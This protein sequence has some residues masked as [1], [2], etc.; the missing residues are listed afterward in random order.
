MLAGLAC[1]FFAKERPLLNKINI[2]IDGPAG[3]GKST[4]ARQVA[5]A[6]G[7]IYVD[8]GAMYRAVTWKALRAGIDLAD[9]S[10]L[11]RMAKELDIQLLPGEVSQK[12][13]LNGEDITDLIRTNEV[14]TTVSLVAQLAEIRELLVEKQQEMARSKGVVMDGRDIGTHVLPD[15]EVKVFLTASARRRAERRYLE[16]RERQEE[17]SLDRLEQEITARDKLDSER[18]TSPL[19]QAKDATLIDSTD[20][21]IE[22]VVERILALSRVRISEV[23]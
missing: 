2:A 4:V 11:L 19:V 9:R 17:V 18:E 15:A 6:L 22:Q 8:T 23:R 7:Y 3:A 14:S 20:L 5:G 1:L 21:S 12:V 10:Q 13:L 16:L